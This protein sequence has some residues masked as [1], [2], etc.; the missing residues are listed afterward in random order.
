MD[1]WLR[2]SHRHQSDWATVDAAIRAESRGTNDEQA[3]AY[4]VVRALVSALGVLV[5]PY[6][7]EPG[8]EPT[9]TY[10]RGFTQAMRDIWSSVAE[11]TAASEG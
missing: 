4:I 5:G 8:F 2:A 1:A 11:G 6:G 7:D 10:L 3:S 9:A